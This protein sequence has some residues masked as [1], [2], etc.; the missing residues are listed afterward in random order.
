MGT[1]SSKHTKNCL[2]QQRWLEQ[3]AVD[4]MRQCIEVANIVALAFEFGTVPVAKFTN[5]PFNLR[6]GVGDDVVTSAL[7]IGLLPVVF[8]VVDVIGHIEN[9]E[10]HRT[11]VE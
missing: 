3:F 8:P 2:N 4:E 9:A 11:H 6:E 10:I 7:D 5:E 1:N